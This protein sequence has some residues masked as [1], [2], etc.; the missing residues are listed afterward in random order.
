M[1][2]RRPPRV[3]TQKAKLQIRVGDS[4]GATAAIAA[5]PANATPR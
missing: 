1:I 3:E 2:A 5:P 4:R